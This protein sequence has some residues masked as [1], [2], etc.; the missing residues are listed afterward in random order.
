[1]SDMNPSPEFEEKIR[2]AMEVPGADPEFVNR[3]KNELARRPVKMK[4]R[5]VLKP[6][7]AIALAVVVVALIASA[8]VAVDALKKLFG[9][10]PGVGLVEN[11]NGMRA[12][13]E[14]VSVTKDGVTLTVTQALVYDNYIQLVYEFSG[15]APENNSS[16][17][18]MEE[19]NT[20]TGIMK[21]RILIAMAS[22]IRDRFWLIFSF[23][24]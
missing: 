15:V 10:V 5:F 20:K 21:S 7:W 4:P 22:A 8:P 3:L 11:S 18:S 24:Q 9:Y 12:L 19:M 14:P 1:M 16:T 13:L 23:V 6:A 17:F 2:K